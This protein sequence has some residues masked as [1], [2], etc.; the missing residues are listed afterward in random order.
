RDA[1]SHRVAVPAYHGRMASPR[2]TVLSEAPDE[3]CVRMVLTDSGGPLS[4]RQVLAG[5]GEQPGLGDKLGQALAE[6]PFVAFRWET[7]AMTVGRLDEPFECVAV[8]DPSLDV[9]PDPSP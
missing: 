2:Y 7:P 3:H 1:D 5:W 6:L 8:D 9:R 4:W